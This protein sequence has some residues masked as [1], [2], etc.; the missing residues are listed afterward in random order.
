MRGRERHSRPDYLA[1]IAGAD[2]PPAERTLAED[3]GENRSQALERDSRQPV[4]PDDLDYR[5]HLRL[6]V[7]EPYRAA[8]DA[9]AARKDCE[10][11]HQG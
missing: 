3:L 1:L 4:Q 2:W 5:L 7:P 8:A 6:G 10:V 9:L 11:D